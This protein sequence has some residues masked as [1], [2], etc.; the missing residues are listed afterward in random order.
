MLKHQ[1]RTA[2]ELLFD[3]DRGIVL[4]L[5]TSREAKEAVLHPADLRARYAA[6][7]STQ[8]VPPTWWLTDSRNLVNASRCR[9]AQCIDEFTGAQVCFTVALDG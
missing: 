7:E 6:A 5:Y 8:V 9:C 3:R 1:A 2:P 4:R